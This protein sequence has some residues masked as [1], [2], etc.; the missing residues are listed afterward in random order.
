MYNACFKNVNLI[1]VEARTPTESVAN[2]NVTQFFVSL[3]Y[4]SV[5]ND[6]FAS[7]TTS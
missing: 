7:F 1:C 6:A 2:I 5:K 3:Q 4:A